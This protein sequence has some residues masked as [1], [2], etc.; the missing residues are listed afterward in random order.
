M[1]PVSNPKQTRQ[2]LII[3]CKLVDKKIIED[4]NKRRH[5]AINQ[6]LSVIKQKIN[7]EKY[8]NVL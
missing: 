4:L 6:L 2:I 5:D 1:R 3:R 8:E 7:G